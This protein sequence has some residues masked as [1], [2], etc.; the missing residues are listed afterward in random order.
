M[1]ALKTHERIRQGAEGDRKEVKREPQ[2]V[3]QRQRGEDLRRGHRISEHAARAIYDGA[4]KIRR[5][6][7][8]RDVGFSDGCFVERRVEQRHT[9]GC[10]AKKAW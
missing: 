1:D 5:G 10:T 6:K 3:E 8:K 7:Q 9:E 2:L 4:G